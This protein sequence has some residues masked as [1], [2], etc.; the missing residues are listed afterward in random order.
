MAKDGGVL[1]YLDQ[2]G[3]G[4][5]IANKMRAYHLQ[6]QGFDTFDADEVLGFGHD[7]R[8]FD[9]AASM[10]KTLG[11]AK[12]DLL[13]NNPLKVDAL[14]V[15]GLEV[16]SRRIL[17]RATDQNVRYLTT[18]RERAGHMIDFDAL[19]RGV[20]VRAGIRTTRKTPLSARAG[21]RRGRRQRDERRP[22][23][24]PRIGRVGSSRRP[25]GCF[26]Q[27]TKVEPKVGV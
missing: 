1:L 14:R 7:Q 27:A 15:A 4:N 5:G 19:A 25:T 9:F 8:F 21:G 3:R 16:T 17:G 6:A 2:E 24:R 12:V 23:A 22:I 10:L 13:T 26:D 18:K 11:V 20:D